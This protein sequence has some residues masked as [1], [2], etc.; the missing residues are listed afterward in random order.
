MDTQT[1]KNDDVIVSDATGTR[2]K[3][4][5]CESDK[6]IRYKNILEL[7]FIRRIGIYRFGRRSRGSNQIFR[8]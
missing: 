7:I 3:E 6:F 8:F 1:T 4:T 2:K 5:V